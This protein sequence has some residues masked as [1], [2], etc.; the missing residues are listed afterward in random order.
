MKAFI[1]APYRGKDEESV[2][3]NIFIANA[4]GRMVK[5]RFG[6][7]PIIV[8]NMI[9]DLWGYDDFPPDTIEDNK[10]V[11]FNRIVFDQCD[12]V[13]L[14]GDFITHG[15]KT[16]LKWAYDGSKRVEYVKNSDLAKWMIG[17]ERIMDI[18]RHTI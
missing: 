2:K 13:I 12:W 4:F 7:E 3:Y 9:K 5:D 10:I 16:E 1:S 11:K 6:V 14:C 17:E 15:M 8:H 18:G